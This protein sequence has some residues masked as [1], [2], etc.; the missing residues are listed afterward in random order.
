MTLSTTINKASYSGDGNTATFNYNF[1]IFTNSDLKVIIRSA[2]GTETL[3][4]ITTHYTVSGAGSNSGGSVTFTGGN[5]PTNT[6]TV[7]LQRVVPLTQTHDYVEND[8]FPAESH[9]QGLDR[10]TMHVQQIQEE[11]DRSIKAS[12]SNTITSTEFGQSPT[13]RAN[14]L[15]GFDSAG[16]INVTT[17]IGTYRGNWSASTAYN[18]RDIVKDTNTNNIFIFILI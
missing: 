16:D 5:I 6:E 14:K 3:K 9:E 4:T 17:A 15:F 11:V 1:K 2:S 7:I 18:E 10:L 8:P 13:E 12:V